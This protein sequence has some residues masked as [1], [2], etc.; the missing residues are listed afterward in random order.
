MVDLK[1]KPLTNPD[2]DELSALYMKVLRYKSETFDEDYVPFTPAYTKY[3]TEINF[4]NL[5]TFFGIYSG[6][7]L[8]GTIGGTIIPIS[9]QDVEL[10]GSAITSYAIDPDLPLDREQKKNLFQQFVKK[11]KEFDVDFIWVAIIKDLNSEEM[12]IFKE[13][14]EFVRVSKN[15]EN[16]V[17][18][19][20]SEGVDILRQK[21]KMNIVLAQL[22]KTMAGMKDPPELEGIIR[23]ATPEDFPKMV[24]LF[25]N[26]STKLPLTQI[27]TLESLQR[28]LD[29]TS[30]LDSLDYSVIKK[31]FP[32]TPF[33]RHTKV[34]ERDQKIIAALLYRV[35]FVRFKNGDAPFGFWDYVAFS[36]DLDVEEKKAFLITM[37]N[38]LYHKAIIINV[39]LPYYDYKAIDKAGFMSERR[40][41]PLFILPLTEKGQKLLEL[42]RITKFYLPTLTDFA[43]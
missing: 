25:N 6:E 10:V 12:K 34:W 2:W 21:K 41:T 43:I 40:K 13:E 26:Y 37:Y 38:E 29:V 20:G 39:F 15:V 22:A 28:Y 24:E 7:N 35:V 33:G 11:I 9:F 19:L 42:E 31:E 1:L 14:L 17:K 5:Q 32:S 18:L 3:A 30:Q 4:S 8:V 16:L 23:D 27:W 36:Q